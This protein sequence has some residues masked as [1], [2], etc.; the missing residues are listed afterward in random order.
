MASPLASRDGWPPA[1]GSGRA[2]STPPPIVGIAGD[3]GCP[4]VSWQ[5]VPAFAGCWDCMWRGCS[6][7]LAACAS[8]CVC[9]QAV[10][11]AI[12]CANGGGGAGACFTDAPPPKGLS[13]AASVCLDF[14]AIDCGCATGSIGTSSDASTCTRTLM[15]T[16]GGGGGDGQCTFS[17]SEVC[18]GETYQV[19]CACPQATCTCMGPSAKVISFGG[20]P[21]CSPPPTLG[22]PMS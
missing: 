22:S 7:Q 9:S 3:G 20:C 13:P 12:A 8:D 17:Q 6:T 21:N 11:N 2:G 18:G 14:A 15:P 16:G 10:A 5:P 1:T 19:I 4:A